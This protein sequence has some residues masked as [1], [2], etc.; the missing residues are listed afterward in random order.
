[1][2]EEGRFGRPAFGPELN[3]KLYDDESERGEGGDLQEDDG[4]K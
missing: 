3:Y 2:T 1:M 4:W